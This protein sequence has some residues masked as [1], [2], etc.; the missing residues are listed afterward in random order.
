MTDR[1]NLEKELS[2]LAEHLNARPGLAPRVMQQVRRGVVMQEPTSF[3]NRLGTA[4][5][6]PAARYAAALGV[7]L[8]VALVV[9][10][11]L[12]PARHSSIAF[13]D[14]QEAL[15]QIE[16]AILEFHFPACPWLDCKQLWR[17]D[18][19]VIRE[20]EST[21]VVCL[22]DIDDGKSFY[23]NPKKKTATILAANRTADPLH[24]GA[25]SA[26]PREFLD[27][28]AR[29]E[30]AAVKPLGEQELGGRKLIGFAMPRDEFAADY[31][32]LCSVW[33]DPETRLP[34]RYEGVPEDPSNLAASFLHNVVTF[35]FNQPL[36]A[37][38]F[39]ASVP[40]G[41]TVSEDNLDAVVEPLVPPLPA[42]DPLASPVVEP[43]VGIGQ[44]RFGMSLKQVLEVLGRP[45][46]A[47]AHWENTAEE[48]KLVDETSR[49]ASEEA[50]AKGLKGS[51]R[52]LFVQNAVRDLHLRKRP[53]EGMSLEY[54]SRGFA[55]ITSEDQGL[56]R[57][58]CSA[59]Y[60]DR[61]PF[62]GKTSKG[63]RMGAT[64]PEIEQA[65]GTPDVKSE[66][67]DGKAWLYY[68]ALHTAFDL[69][70]GR[71]WELSLEKP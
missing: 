68:Q 53:W 71:L 1:Q 40:E 46:Y 22:H 59:A 33:V 25:K 58:F 60:V 26:T 67:P 31:R 45:D 64:V 2:R 35:T 50:A 43:N 65:Y 13:A 3:F 20:E 54:Y 49:K 69:R 34:V 41:Y 15:R 38:L 14:V 23:I 55:L 44:A 5:R 19:A 17:R 9:F 29:L 30:S 16:T 32:M 28:L 12:K 42:N 18:C 63:I 8:I 56:I 37:S 27:K 39:H 51:E 66:D 21:G 47:G 10:N 36:A 6:Q 11:G 4:I 52:S 62:T 70:N 61:R 48:T 24:M 7:A 57:I